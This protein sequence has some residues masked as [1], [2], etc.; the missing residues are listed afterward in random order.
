MDDLSDDELSNIV[1]SPTGTCECW[2]C[3]M[4]KELIR[5]RATMKRLDAWAGHMEAHPERGIGLLD[6]AADLRNRMKGG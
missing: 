5:H 1:R 6:I 3:R 4:A 2:K